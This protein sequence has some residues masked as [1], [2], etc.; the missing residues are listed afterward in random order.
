[1]PVIAIGK[2]RTQSVFIQEEQFTCILCQEKPTTKSGDRPLVCSAYVQRSTNLSKGPGQPV[3]EGDD[4]DPLVAHRDQ[5]V[6]VHTSSCGHVMHGECWQ[7]FVESMLA[8]ERLSR[9]LRIQSPVDT[10]KRE[11]LC[12]L[13]EGLSNTVV[14][15]LPPIVPHEER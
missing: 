10:T 3:E 12:P 13:C 11:F 15:L 6:G 2:N 4:A 8:N 1:M 9:M 7:R 5:R 14:P